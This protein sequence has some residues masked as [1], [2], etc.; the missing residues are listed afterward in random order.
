MH[1][2]CAAGITSGPDGPVADLR[3]RLEGGKL[4]KVDSFVRQVL[5]PQAG[6][7]KFAGPVNIKLRLALIEGV[8][9]CTD[10]AGSAVHYKH[11]K[12]LQQP[13]V[14]GSHSNSQQAEATA[15]IRP[16]SHALSQ[17]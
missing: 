10:P 8:T 12:A 5:F 15:A 4:G 1:D 14:Q 16:L 2:M 13:A 7:V 9:Y 6:L 11:T 17:Q 3:I